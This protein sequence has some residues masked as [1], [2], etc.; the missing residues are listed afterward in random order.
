MI[1][2]Y[3]GTDETITIYEGNKPRFVCE[4][5]ASENTKECEYCGE[6]RLVDCDGVCIACEE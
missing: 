5:C 3:C 2:E 1:C 6:E 4:E